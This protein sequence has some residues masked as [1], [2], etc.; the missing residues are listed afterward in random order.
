M[1]QRADSTFRAAIDGFAHLGSRSIFSVETDLDYA[2]FCRDTGRLDRADS[3]YVRV[4]SSLD[5]TQAATRSVLGKCRVGR[6]YLRA[7]RGRHAEAESMM[8]AGLAMQRGDGPEDS[9]SLAESHVLWA[10]A[11]ARAGNLDG[12][13]EE[14]RRAARC[15]A[16]EFEAAKYAELAPGRSRPDYPLRAPR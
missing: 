12:A 10:A 9:P 14:L 16:T 5:S 11:R 7:L 3:F 13:I 15:G 1:A 4:E 8:Q 2:G 6:G